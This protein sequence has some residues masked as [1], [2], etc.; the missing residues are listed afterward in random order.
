MNPIVI[1]ERIKSEDVFNKYMSEVEEK[2][3]EIKKREEEES[4]NEAIYKELREAFEQKEREISI[5]KLK[6]RIKE[7]KKNLDKERKIEKV[8]DDVD[9]G[10]ASSED[11]DLWRMKKV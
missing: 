2:L 9:E 5:E 7:K 6:N 11:D 10:D 4:V 8:I 1:E 3:K